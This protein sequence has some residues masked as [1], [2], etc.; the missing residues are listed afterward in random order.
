V[1]RHIIDEVVLEIANFLAAL[2]RADMIAVDPR[3]LLPV[4]PDLVVEDFHIFSIANKE[5][6]GSPNGHLPGGEPLCSLSL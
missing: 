1:P 6:S 4:P 5:Q 3:D 2:I